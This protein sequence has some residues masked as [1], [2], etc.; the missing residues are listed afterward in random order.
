MKIVKANAI[1]LVLSILG[2]SQAV[3]AF[4]NQTH[5]VVL[6]EDNFE[7]ELQKNPLLVMIHLPG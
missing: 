7:K 6:S 1:L 2:T 4:D 3:G 5:V